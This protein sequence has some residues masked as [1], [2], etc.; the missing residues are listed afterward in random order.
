MVIPP[1]LPGAFCSSHTPLATQCP[2][3]ASR[4]ACPS[5]QTRLESLGVRG[6]VMGSFGLPNSFDFSHTLPH[7]DP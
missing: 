1:E 3:W 2:L 5:V 7:R 4:A 6:V